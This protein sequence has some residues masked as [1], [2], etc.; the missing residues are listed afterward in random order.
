MALNKDKSRKLAELEGF[1]QLTEVQRRVNTE[2]NNY[3]DLI[4]QSQTGTGKTHAYLFYLLDR[5]DATSNTVQ[6]IIVA[7]TRE[8]ATQIYGMAKRIQDV[9][10]IRIDLMV[11]GTDR[12]RVIRSLEK[13]PQIIIGTPGRIADLFINAAALRCDQAR[14]F[15]LDEADTIFE[16]GFLEDVDRIVS[17]LKNDAQLL[18]FSATVPQGLKPFIKKYLKQPHIIE[19]DEDPVFKPQID[20]ILV[21]K[22]HMTNEEALLDIFPGINPL[23]CLIFTNT[24]QETT[25]IAAMLRDHGVDCLELHGDLTPRV[26]KS[27]LLRIQRNEVKYIVATDIA[28]RGI[29]LPEITHVINCGLPSAEHLSFY[30]HRA[31]RTGRSGKTGYCYSLVSKHD[32]KQVETLIKQGIKFSYKRYS[33]GE[34]QDAKAFVQQPR[35]NKRT[36]P[37]ILKIVNNKKSNVVKPGYKKKKQAAIEKIERKRRREMIEKSIQQLKKDRAKEKQ[38][39]KNDM[40]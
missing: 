30:I 22:R 10:D 21:N 11:G 38:R 9:V 31:G 2:K 36:N 13:Q 20:H 29:D 6:A 25:L 19:V 17:R 40:E 15:V 28:A 4:V 33:Q 24:R 26:R 12:D 1:K 7:P 35:A 34:W 32:L 18:L 14:Y 8:L 16:Y 27:T 3:H 39:S 23:C 5:I 37:E